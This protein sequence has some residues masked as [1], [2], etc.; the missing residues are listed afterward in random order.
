MSKI[1]KIERIPYKGWLYGI[2][3]DED[4]SFVANGIVVHNCEE[5]VNQD[6]KFDIISKS[7]TK[8]ADAPL[9]PDAELL[10][11][12]G[13]FKTLF[14]LHH[15]LGTYEVVLYDRLTKEILE[16]DDDCDIVDA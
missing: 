16:Q 5:G 4:E 7:M 12:F 1:V 6:A 10:R 8:N 3:V 15:T 9:M 2:E 14:S 11:Y 13:A